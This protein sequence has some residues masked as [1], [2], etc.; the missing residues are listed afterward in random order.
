MSNNATLSDTKRRLLNQ[1]VQQR[2]IPPADTSAI[3]RRPSSGPAPLSLSQERLVLRAQNVSRASL[4]NESITVKFRRP[5]DR[6]V[7]QISMAEVIR[8]H[9]ILRTRYDMVS[10]Q[11]VQVVAPA[12]DNFALGL[13]DFRRGS[14]RQKR[15]DLSTLSLK[16]TAQPFD[17]HQGPLLRALLVAMNES[18]SWLVMTAHQS[19]IDGVSVYQIF[20]RELFT[21]YQAFSAN[22]ASP[23]SELPLQ[24]S[25]FAYWQREWL[26]RA[27]I[28][29]QVGYWRTQLGSGSHAPRWPTH[30]SKLQRRTFRGFIR[31]FV[32]DRHV[33]DAASALGR[34]HGVTMFAVLLSAFYSLLHLYT[35]QRDLTV[36]TLSP[37]GRKR[38][39]VQ[40]LIGYF[41]NPVALRVDLADD[42]PF[43]EL[44]RRVQVTISEAISNDDVPFEQIVET[45]DSHS[46]PSRN[47]YFDAVISLQPCLPD[48][49]AVWSVTSMDAE[50]GAAAFDLYLAFIDRP[51]GLDVRAQYNPDIFAVEEL[52]QTIRDFEA[53]LA[54]TTEHPEERISRLHL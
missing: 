12:L 26:T 27:E 6:D 46:D 30:K 16:Q 37:S 2:T 36:G 25:D 23:L 33:A 29:R 35:G 22:R 28:L 18:E 21:I 13:V 17:L 41:L 10:G 8:R 42:P 34:G 7:L 5:V 54:F 48:S 44:L 51:E 19:I 52:Q 47:P 14:E 45:L 24:F 9:Q 20:P 40:G 38:S 11:L 32:L 15:D 31:R 4:Y 39:E 49:A 50:S 53:L 3:Q 43:T 1:F